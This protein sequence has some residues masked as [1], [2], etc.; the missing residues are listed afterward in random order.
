MPAT[1]VNFL[2]INYAKNK[3]RAATDRGL[4]E[5]DLYTSSLPKAVIAVNS[6]EVSCYK[7][8]LQF[9][10]H[11]VVS[12][13][14]AQWNWTFQGGMPST[15][16]VERPLVFYN[17]VG[18]Y[19]V[20]LT[21][22]DALGNSSTT[23]DTFITVLADE[24][25]LDTV[26]GLALDLTSSTTD[27]L[28]VPPLPLHSNNLT[29]SAWVKLKGNQPNYAA[30]FMSENGCGFGF[31]GNDNQLQYHWKNNFWSWNS[32]LKADTSVWQHIALVVTPTNSKL[33]LKR[34]SC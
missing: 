26:P 14:N 29:I 1:D 7:T 20:S 9:A 32:G 23:L 34:H 22:I 25:G 15:S 21:I 13:Q 4:W 10:C 3:I 27:F 28:E 16:T 6:T 19:A 31:K 8:P 18:R 30:I 24:C 2:H 5:N 12:G 33:Y 17:Q 11:S